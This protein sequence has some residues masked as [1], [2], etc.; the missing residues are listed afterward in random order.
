M[1]LGW[2][3]LHHQHQLLYHDYLEGP[4]MMNEA[5]KKMLD[6]FGG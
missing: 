2:W 4:P 3:Y 5:R 6:D 1:T